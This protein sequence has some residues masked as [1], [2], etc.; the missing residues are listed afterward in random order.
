MGDWAQ[1]VRRLVDHP[2]HA[3]AEVITQ[4]CDNLN[5]HDIGSRYEAFEPAEASL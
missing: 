4:V 3:A 1:Q 5:T 2:R